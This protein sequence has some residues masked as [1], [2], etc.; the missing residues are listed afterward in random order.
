MSR[1]L[2]AK[3]DFPM[4]NSHHILLARVRSADLGEAIPTARELAEHLGGRLKIVGNVALAEFAY[5]Q[6]T[7][8]QI[9][10]GERTSHF[11][12]VLRDA[13]VSEKKIRKTQWE[14]AEDSIVHLP[15]GWREAMG[16]QIELSR[17]KSSLAGFTVWSADYTMAVTGALNGWLRF[18]TD[19]KLPPI[20]NGSSLDAYG[21]WLIDAEQRAAPVS[22]RTASNYL[23]RIQA[24]LGVVERNEISHARAFVVRDIREKADVVGATTKTGSQL[25]GATTLYDLGFD[26][27]QSARARQTR[28]LH[29]AKDFRNGL[30][31]SVAAALPQRA[32]AL[33]ALDFA[34]TLRLQGGDE[35]HIRI[36]AHFLKGREDEKDGEPFD[37]TFHNARLAEA[38]E[39]YRLT[40]RPLFDDGTCLLPSIR[41]PE[42]SISESQIGCLVRDITKQFLG[43]RISIHRV[44][45]NVMTDASEH[46]NGGRMASKVLL[47]HADIGSGDPYDYS[48]G[49]KVRREFADFIE[50][51]RSSPV[52]LNL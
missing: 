41:A 13:R 24:G 26:L 31:L 30:I 34:T 12:R 47:G 23:S 4:N 37:V 49:M 22:L 42:Q 27:M 25:V 3:R 9:W 28:G 40:F 51:K 48:N 16:R 43:V 52:D 19:R 21:S 44:R 18:A 38:L 1:V 39:E 35:I 14:K 50:D 45:D 46:L 20:P 11:A 8:A 10:G 6:K 2:P 29:A 33:S 7:A 5:L 32:R 17:K 15:S 36:P